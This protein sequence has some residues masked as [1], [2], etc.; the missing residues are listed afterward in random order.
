[1]AIP[2]VTNIGSGGRRR[3]YVIGGAALAVALLLLAGIVLGGAPRG[4]RLVVFL[5][6]LVGALGFLQAQ[7]GT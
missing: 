4:A 5:P 3:R 7:G 1:M 6:F 2:L